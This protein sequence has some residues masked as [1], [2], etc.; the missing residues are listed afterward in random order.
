L[1]AWRFASR[2][3]CTPRRSDAISRDEH[4]NELF[5]RWLLST[6]E[7]LQKLTTSDLYLIKKH[8]FKK[9]LYPQLCEYIESGMSGF[10]RMDRVGSTWL[11]RLWRN[12]IRRSLFLVI[13]FVS[14][15]M[16]AETLIPQGPP[17]PYLPSGVSLPQGVPNRLLP[18][19]L[20][21]IHRLK[22][23]DV[24]NGGAVPAAPIGGYA[25]FASST[26]FYGLDKSDVNWGDWYLVGIGNTPRLIGKQILDDLIIYFFDQGWT[27]EYRVELPD[28][29]QRRTDAPL[30][31][32]WVPL[33]IAKSPIE[34]TSPSPPPTT[35]LYPHQRRTPRSMLSSS[36]IKV[37]PSGYFAPMRKFT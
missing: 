18:V 37:I 25:V 29:S 11:C 32:A 34:T 28:Y 24:M 1:K 10:K 20:G 8:L 3:F 2:L 19:T 22:P 9:F 6:R 7:P 4:P 15:N 5:G 31:L 33:A 14:S 27:G 17:A 35:R 23:S 16:L 13:C 36:P 21:E 26:R 12:G 30:F